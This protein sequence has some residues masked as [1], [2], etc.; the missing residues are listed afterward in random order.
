MLITEEI[1]PL[2]AHRIALEPER[3][4]LMVDSSNLLHDLP[5]LHRRIEEDGYLLLR[6]YLDQELVIDARR[7][8]TDR[9]MR[10]GFL[11]P[12]TD[13]MDAM[14]APGKNPGWYPNIV[15][16]NVP[17]RHTLRSGRMMELFDRF[18]GGPSFCFDYTWFRLLMPGTGTPPHSDIVYMG[19]GTH[20]LYTAWTP[21][22]TADFVTGGLTILEG[23]HR[24]QRLRETYGQMDV[25]TFCA[26]H[27]PDSKS[28]KGPW[29]KTGGSLGPNLNQL[30]RSLG[31][32][33]VVGEFEPG[34]VVIFSVY[35]VHAG[36]DNHS[37]SFRL[38]SD[39]RYQLSSDPKDERWIGENPIA[40]GPEGKRGLIC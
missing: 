37:Q 7:V 36:L 34:D 12:G 6:G 8:L 15:K 31:G 27:P 13:P 19:R 5:A 11:V 38:S 23:S 2:T 10:E 18:L 39:T 20:N 30:S 29:A 16:D 26:N 4:S 17:L 24:H 25:D 22:G 14:A 40:H 32:R 9:L 21:I 28:G 33:W 1:P 35:A 3:L